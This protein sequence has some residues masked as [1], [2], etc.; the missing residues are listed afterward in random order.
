MATLTTDGAGQAGRAWEQAALAEAGATSSVR[1]RQIRARAL[2]MWPP[3][4]TVRTLVGSEGLAG[5][6]N[7]IRHS[8]GS[9]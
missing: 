2:T 4:E 1:A 7:E 6:P 3:L 8:R 5:S 9:C